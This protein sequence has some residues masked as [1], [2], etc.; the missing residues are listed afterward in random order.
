MNCKN[1]EQNG[2]R[3]VTNASRRCEVKGLM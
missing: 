2:L 1:D 3:S